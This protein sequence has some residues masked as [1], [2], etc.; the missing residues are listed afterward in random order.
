MACARDPQPQLLWALDRSFCEPLSV[1][2]LV[3]GLCMGPLDGNDLLGVKTLANIDDHLFLLRRARTKPHVPQKCYTS[4]AQY[5]T[6]K[7]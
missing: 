2:L 7:C 3:Y 4:G 6:K 5:N 1:I